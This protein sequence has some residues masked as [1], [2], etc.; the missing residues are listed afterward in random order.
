MACP[1]SRSSPWN[2]MRLPRGRILLVADQ[3]AGDAVQF[4]RYIPLVAERCRE[5]I[6]AAPPEL[7]DLLRSAQGLTRVVTRYED[8]GSVDVFCIL[9]SLP[10]L[11]GTTLETIP[12]SVPYL[13]VDAARSAAW[14]ARLDARTPPGLASGGHCV[15]GRPRASRRSVAID[16]PGRMETPPRRAERD[17]HLSA[18]VG[19]GTGPRL[20][21]VGQPPDRPDRR[22][23]RLRRHRRAGSGPRSRRLRGH[24][25]C[26]HRG[27]SR[28]A[29]MGAPG[30]AAR[31]A[32]A[33]RPRGQSLVSDAPAVPPGGAGPVGGSSPTYRGEVTGRSWGRLEAVGPLTSLDRS[34]TV[35]AAVGAAHSSRR[36]AHAAR[37]GALDGG[38]PWRRA[39]RRRSRSSG[40]K[41]SRVRDL[42][43]TKDS[44]VRGGAKRTRTV[45]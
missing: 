19:S 36:S 31:L 34:S 27:R 6:L 18:K 1:G 23:G 33:P 7:A 15:G 12:G 2:G 41:G 38:F 4:A 28:K 29:R 21:D 11:L 24:L 17:L 45:T 26:A 40:G 20:R 25:H 30:M 10:F 8:V 14:K 13:T 9:S 5:V 44:V 16:A 42:R 37:A 35:A 39:R 43:A 3:G 32:V 22:A